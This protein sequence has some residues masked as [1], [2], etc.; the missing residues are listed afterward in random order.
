MLSP[1]QRHFRGPIMRSPIFRAAAGTGL[2]LAL[3]VSASAGGNE[4][5]YQLALP[6]FEFEFPRDHGPHENFRTEWWYFT[7]HLMTG[8]RRAYGYELTFFRMG[9]R[10][11]NAAPNPSQWSPGD[12]YFAHFAVTDEAGSAFHY[13]EERARTGV[14]VAGVVADPFRFWI[15]GW[16]LE[17]RGKGFRLAAEEGGLA[18]RLDLEP[19]KPIVVHGLEGVSQKSDGPGQATHYYSLTRME[20]SGEVEIRGRKYTVTGLSWMDH[21]FGSNWM[22]P[23]QVGWD[24]FSVQIEDG[25]E[26]MLYRMRRRDGRKDLHSSGTWVLPDG[27][28][29]HLA[30]ADFEIEETGKWMSPKS[31][32]VYPMGWRVRVPQAGL[33]LGLAP[34]LLDQ[35]LVTHQSTQVTYWEGSVRVE[36]ESSGRSVKGLGYV[37]MTGYAGPLVSEF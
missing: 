21:E 1:V 33:D 30:H 3:G 6:G 13:F 22:S 11:R 18:V 4:F 10:D 14:G 16:S 9:L 31:K 36:C 24:W 2:F 19:R 34:A 15:G 37:E 20:T 23:E 8:D 29:R 35:E 27:A 12:L 17:A 7:G 32:A 26:L 28:S 25:N 5:R